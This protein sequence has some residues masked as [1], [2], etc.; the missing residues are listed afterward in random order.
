MQ[1]LRAEQG[2]DGQS[3]EQAAAAVDAQKQSQQIA[4]LVA[5]IRHLQLDLEYHQQKLDQTS[6]EKQKL[7][8]DMKK[9]QAELLEARQQVE[10]KDQMLRHREVDLAHLKKELKSPRPGGAGGRD[11]GPGDSNEGVLAAL[12]TEAAAKDS[13]LIVS[14][15][16]LHKEKLMRE[17]LEQKNLKLMERMQKLMM[18]VETM[19]KENVTLEHSLST[20]ERVCEE[21]DAQLRQVTQKARQLHRLAKVSK[22]S[23]RTGAGQ[24]SVLEL[25]APLREGLPPL[26]RS[27]RSIDSAGGRRSG[28]S[29]PRTPRTPRAPASPY[30]R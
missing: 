16:E 12:R 10:E 1:R 7:A 24:A 23:A 20:K 3:E 8:K 2:G 6:E 15:Y 5:D 25:E 17:R 28:M 4:N 11:I 30:G 26:D 22:S 21:K 27:Q 13:A 9:C 19:R 18:V 29:T 14:H